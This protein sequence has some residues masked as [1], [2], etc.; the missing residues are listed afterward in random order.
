MGADVSRENPRWD[1]HAENT[2][3]E[4]KSLSRRRPKSSE[5]IKSPGSG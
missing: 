5:K 4:K 2:E 1:T 3:K